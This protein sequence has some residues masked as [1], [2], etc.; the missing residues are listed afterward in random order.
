MGG[1]VRTILSVTGTRSE[2]D[3]MFPAYKA[4]DE[5][6]ALS[7]SLIVTGAHLSKN[8]GYTVNQIKKDGF[9]ITETLESLIDGDQDVS[10]LKGAA[11]Q[12]LGLAQIIDRAKPDY[13]MVFGDREE[14]LTTAMCSAYLNIPL[15]H[16]SGGDRVVGNVDD[17][18]RHAV[19]K[20]AHIHFTTSESSCERILRMG[21]QAFR[22]HFVGNPGIDRLAMTEVLCKKEVL[23]YYEFK[24]QSLPLLV[25]VQHAIS[26]EID[27]SYNQM[28]ITMEAVKS[29]GYNTVM[30]YPNSD[31]GSR[32]I[33][34]CIDEYRHI[35]NLKISKFIP[36]P[37]F[38]NTLRY[39]DCLIGNSSLGLLEAPYFNL[40]VVNIGNRQAKRFHAGNVLFVDHDVSEIVAA[41]KKAVNNID[42]R[43]YVANL[44]PV[45]GDGTA[46]KK[47][48]DI[49]LKI[50]YD[51][52]LI[53]KDISY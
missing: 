18:I 41:T 5:S 15:I 17:Q 24:D 14:T 28:K 53:I 47:I 1:I 25:L 29:L 51:Q 8:F 45:F 9:H 39:A 33:I 35:P 12:L 7:L 13:L 27:Q 21:E 22:V 32:D 40:P 30:S 38:V 3:L 23:D 52:S 6:D 20:L 46:A 44:P 43:S 42:Y 37:E 36:R 31:A 48:V 10:R 49:I 26:T 50:P 19:T 16:I 4:I 11:V 2:Y 34:R